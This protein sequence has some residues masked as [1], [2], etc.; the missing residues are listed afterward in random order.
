[1]WCVAKLDDEYIK[2]MEDILNIYEKPYN[3][4]EPVICVDEKPVTLRGNAWECVGIRENQSPFLKVNPLV[5]IMNI[6][7]MVL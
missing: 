5:K 1:M 4:K 2:R 7:K 3:G 6:L